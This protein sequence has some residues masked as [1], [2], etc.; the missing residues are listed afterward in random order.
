MNCFPLS[1]AVVS[2][3]ATLQGKPHLSC[4]YFLH[5][6]VALNSYLGLFALY[7][8]ILLTTYKIDKGGN[9]LPKIINA[10]RKLVRV[11]NFV[12]NRTN[13]K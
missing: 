13:T 11:S 10:I 7:K 2:L 9:S 12:Q 5:N 3:Y 1:P 8:R 4:A 6:T